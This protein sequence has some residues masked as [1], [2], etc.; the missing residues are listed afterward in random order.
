M[1]RDGPAAALGNELGTLIALSSFVR[2][3]SDQ[4]Q[5]ERSTAFRGARRRAL[6]QTNINIRGGVVMNRVPLLPGFWGGLS[7]LQ[8]EMDRLF[9]HWVGEP[10]TLAPAAPL[11]NVWEDEEAFRVEAELPGV[12]Q[13]NLQIEVTQRNVLTIS[14]ERQPEPEGNGTWHRRERGLGRFQRV[15]TLPA[16]VE[17]DKVEAKLENGVLQLVLPKAEEAKPR[18]IAVKGE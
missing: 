8:G 5:A 13:E 1:S 2:Q 11:V 7:R 9:E 14:G 6:Q 4:R 16:P 10:Q 18:R 12:K 17:P 3:V 15:L